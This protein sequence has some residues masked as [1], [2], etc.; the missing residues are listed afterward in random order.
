MNNK[1]NI[2]ILLLIIITLSGCYSLKAIKN[3]KPGVKVNPNAPSLSIQKDQTSFYFTKKL[4][5]NVQ[6]YLD[7]SLVNSNTNSFIVIKNDTIIYEKY[8][9]GH[10]SSQLQTSWSVAKS[11]VSVLLGIAIDQGKVKST[12]EPITNYIPELLKNDSRFANITIQNILDM[13]SGVDFRE[14]YTNPFSKMAKL[15][16]GNNINSLIANLKIK[17]DP[18]KNFEYTSINTQLLRIVIERS[19]GVKINDF[20]QEQLWRPLQMESNATWNIDSYKHNNI[21]ASCCLNAIPLDFAKFGRLILNQGSWNGKQIVSKEW[22]VSSTSKEAFYKQ[23]NGFMSYHN[24]WW[25][26][27]D[28]FLMFKDSIEASTYKKSHTFTGNARKS[29]RGNYFVVPEIKGDFYAQGFRGQIIYINPINKVI[30]IRLGTDSNKQYMVNNYSTW[31]LY[32]FIQAF[33]QSL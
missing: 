16:Y 23:A 17:K 4:D 20:M 30:I 14:Y 31:Q 9:N 24:Q 18:N 27:G 12:S 6:A 8:F 25:G 28:N 7:S 2:S 33:G 22:V 13:R 15:Q 32:E 11:F 3:G 5:Y 1:I 29:V 10:E 26:V 21:K 19:T